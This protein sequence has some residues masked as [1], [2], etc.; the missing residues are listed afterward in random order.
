MNSSEPGDEDP[1]D[2]EDDWSHGLDQL[3]DERYTAAG[4]IDAASA[5]DALLPWL[6][7]E[8]PLATQGEEIDGL[9]HATDGSI[10]IQNADGSG[11]VQSAEGALYAIRTRQGT[12]LG[13]SNQSIIW[14]DG[15]DPTNETVVDTVSTISF[16]FVAHLATEKTQ[17]ETTQ[18]GTILASGMSGP[19]T[20]AETNPLI[21]GI[22][23]IDI[24]DNNRSQTGLLLTHR[25]GVQFY[26]GKDRTLTP[27]DSADLYG[28]VPFDGCRGTPVPSAG[29]A[30]DLLMPQQVA[31]HEAYIRQGE[32]FFIPAKQH[33]VRSLRGTQAPDAISQPNASPLYPYIPHEWTTRISNDSFINRAHARFSNL[34]TDA[35]T[36][37]DVFAH[38]RQLDSTDAYVDAHQLAEGIY[39]RGPLRYDGYESSIESIDVWHRAASYPRHLSMSVRRDVPFGNGTRGRSS[40]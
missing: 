39:I 29:D 33:T 27:D 30:F 13:N 5:A 3:P 12:I 8:Y 6:Q 37:R 35:T 16:D 26:V 36:P 22:A 2:F 32:W 28:Y 15:V 7:M 31:A 34:P 25:T 24:L 10:A 18:K 11:L 21:R 9:I 1:S 17:L 14:P 4:G 19:E 38:V 40:T 20:S 23:E